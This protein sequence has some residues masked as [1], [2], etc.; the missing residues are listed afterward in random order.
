MCHEGTKAL[1][2][3]YVARCVCATN[4]LKGVNTY[5]L[6]AIAAFKLFESC[7]LHLCFEIVEL[8]SERVAFYQFDDEELGVEIIL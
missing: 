8:H 7:H 5:A 1:I 4:A 6:R 3:K 2:F